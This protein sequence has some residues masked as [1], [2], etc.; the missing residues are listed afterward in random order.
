MNDNLLWLEGW[1]GDVVG[2]LTRSP[3]RLLHKYS[4][5]LYYVLN[6]LWHFLNFTHAASF[7]NV[8]LIQ[9]YL[10]LAASV[11]VTIKYMEH[12]LAKEITTWLPDCNLSGPVLLSKTCEILYFICIKPM[13]W[14]ERFCFPYLLEQRAFS[15]LKGRLTAWGLSF[16]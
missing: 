8:I 2:K 10:R 14:K 5:S 13:G 12:S 1:I 4:I 6:L 3:L 9:P 15:S 7:K 11:K 16:E